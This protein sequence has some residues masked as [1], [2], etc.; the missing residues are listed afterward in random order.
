M[1]NYEDIAHKL[2]SFVVSCEL[3]V[4]KL[5]SAATSNVNVESALLDAR[6]LL[7]RITL[8]RKKLRERHKER[9]AL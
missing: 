4:N 1:L 6:E 7:S 2:G 5:E 9:K 3:I 8:V